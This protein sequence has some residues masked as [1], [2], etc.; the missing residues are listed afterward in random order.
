MQS[1]AELRNEFA[2]SRNTRSNP[3]PPNVQ[4]GEQPPA[5]HTNT[6]SPYTKYTVIVA[7]SATLFVGVGYTNAFGVFQEHYQANILKDEKP[8]KIIVIGSTAA[9]LYL[10]PGAF[11]GRF[12][13]LVGYRVS[14]LI[15]AAL[16]VVSMFTASVSTTY[17]HFLTMHAHC[18]HK[19]NESTVRWPSL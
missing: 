3:S 12:A 18:L 8:D 5:E 11:T 7:A 2:L 16:M 19:F 6:Q 13:D 1:E 14:L 15:G 4:A 9:S 17:I 10:I